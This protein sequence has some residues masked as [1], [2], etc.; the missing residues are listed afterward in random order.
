MDHPEDNLV[1][2][3]IENQAVLE[4]QGK[5]QRSM[6]QGQKDLLERFRF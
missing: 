5:G 6:Q 3:H 2:V 1:G 4:E